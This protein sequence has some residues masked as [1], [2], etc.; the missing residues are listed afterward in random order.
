MT[1]SGKVSGRMTQNV[2][3][4]GMQGLLANMPAGELRFSFGADSRDNFYTFSNDPLSTPQSVTDQLGGFFPAG[5]SSGKT[6]SRK[7][8]VSC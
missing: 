1:A 8:M 4:Y 6:T 7:L 3:E 2:V 5:D